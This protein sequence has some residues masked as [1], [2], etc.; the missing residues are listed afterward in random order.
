MATYESVLEASKIT[1]NGCKSSKVTVHG[2]KT[3]KIRMRGLKQG[4]MIVTCLKQ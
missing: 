2:G 3:S 4:C 1:V